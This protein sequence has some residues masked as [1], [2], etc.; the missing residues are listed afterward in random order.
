MEFI[1]F[2]YSIITLLSDYVTNG[3]IKL[4]I[5]GIDFPRCF[6][7]CCAQHCQVRQQRECP[8]RS[9][10]CCFPLRPPRRQAA[11]LRT[12]SVRRLAPSGSPWPWGARPFH[13]RPSMSSSETFLNLP[14]GYTHILSVS[15]LRVTRRCCEGQNE[16]PKQNARSAGEGRPIVPPACSPSFGL[17]RLTSM[18]A[19]EYFN[20]R[21]QGRND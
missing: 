13:I 15:S 19:R 6:N 9:F 7:L 11:P 14:L 20:L 4:T 10:P 8:F 12:F 21:G 1:P 18:I 3:Q 5:L 2:L 17:N 16:T